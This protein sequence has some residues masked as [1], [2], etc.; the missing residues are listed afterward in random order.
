MLVQTNMFRFTRKLG[1][2]WNCKDLKKDQLLKL[3]HWK[4]ERNSNEILNDLD[5]AVYFEM[6]TPFK[7]ASEGLF[8][9]FTNT[10]SS[11]KS[12]LK[13]KKLEYFFPLTTDLQEI[14]TNE[15]PSESLSPLLWK[16]LHPPY[17][18]PRYHREHFSNKKYI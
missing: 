10:K 13:S 16:K 3:S 12:H 17:D 6:W 7:V 8:G 14:T 5:T 18:Y 15:K 1:D 2:S 9:S 4:W 11:I